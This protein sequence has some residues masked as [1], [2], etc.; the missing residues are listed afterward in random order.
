MQEINLDK[1][2]KLLDS[3]GIVMSK[4]NDNTALILRNCVKVRISKAQL[5][6][7]NIAVTIVEIINFIIARNLDG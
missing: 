2:I 4:R 5:K 3:P 6:F 1:N 7:N